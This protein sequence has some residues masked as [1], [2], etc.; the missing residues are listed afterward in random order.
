MRVLKFGGTSVATPESIRHVIAVLRGARREGPAVAVVSA[1]GGVTDTLLGAAATAE[2]GG[3]WRRLWEDLRTR[4]LATATELAPGEAAFLEDLGAGLDELRHLLHGVELLR[5][6]SPRVSDGIAAYGERLSSQIV[7]AALRTAGL[8][9]EAVD[10]RELI[11]TDDQFGRAQVDLDESYRRLRDRLLGDGPLPVLTGFTGATPEGQTTTLGRGGSDYTGA[12]VGA[13]LSARAIEL[14]TDVSGVMTAD[15]RVIAD[16]FVQ[17]HLSYA[18]LMELSHFGAKVVYAPSV[19]PA[20]QAGIPLLIKNTFSPDDPGTVVTD[21]APASDAPI[22]GITSI[23]SVALVRLEGDG[24]VGVPGIAERLFGALAQ[25]RISVILISQSSSEHS[26]CFAVSGDDAKAVEKAVNRAFRDEQQRGEIDPVIVEAAHT[27]VAVVGEQMALQPGIAGLI[28]GVLG[29]HGVNVRAIAQGSSELNISFVVDGAQEIDAVQAIHGAFFHRRSRLN[30]ALAG[31]GRV[32]E[33]LLRQLGDAQSALS[34]RG[35]DLRLRAVARSSRFLE[36][37]D[38]LDVADA[39]TQL[40]AGPET[41]AAETLLQRLAEPAPG[42]TVFIDATASDST[43]AL[44]GPLLERGVHVVAANK[45]PFT[46]SLESYR[47]LLDAAR[48]GGASLRFETTAG[49]GLPVLSTLQAQLATGD[50]LEKLD[51]VLSGTL[52]AVLDRLGPDKPLSVAVREAYDE[53]LTEPHPFDDLSGADVQ[54][55]L[56]ILARLAGRGLE[57]GD[58]DVEPLVPVEFGEL[59][60]DDFWRRLPELDADFERRRLAAEAQ[61][62]RLRYVASLD[63]DGARV[64]TVAVDAEHPAYALAGPD[65]LVAFSTRRYAVSPLV[66]RGPGAGPAVTAAGLFADVL[67]AGLDRM[68]RL[69]P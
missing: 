21:A 4:H 10:T 53:G 2:A 26:I 51:G 28:F 39:M 27:V 42:A 62:E 6:V 59:D 20:R 15:P 58:I 14:W 12:L 36:A 66:V 18:E 54:R 9:A 65:N 50:A 17:E 34:D 30:V 61:G 11:V 3:D 52:N 37:R 23:R 60:L 57:L 8:D 44:Y 64:G 40:D 31:V 33:E 68:P 1:L 67:A 32:G 7:A 49:A 19:H 55:K 56:C 35:V 16:A 24:M 29:D 46:G 25:R 5:E 41:D 63:A 47:A 43:Q 38:G 45:K 48:R 69:D 13:A 22:R